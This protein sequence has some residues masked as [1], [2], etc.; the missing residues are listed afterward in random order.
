MGAMAGTTNS[1][2]K[3]LSF[4]SHRRVLAVLGGGDLRYRAVPRLAERGPGRVDDRLRGQAVPGEQVRRGPRSLGEGVA[5]ADAAQP[6]AKTGLGE[7]L[8]DR[9]AKAA[10]NRVVLRGDDRPGGSG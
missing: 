7:N 6:A 4:C 5:Q 2:G 3:S 1:F 8:G 9:G 10:D